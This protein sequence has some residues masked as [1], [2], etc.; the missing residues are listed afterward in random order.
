M[1]F[2]NFIQLI[3][4]ALLSFYYVIFFSK[5]GFFIKYLIND[6]VLYFFKS[7]KSIKIIII[8]I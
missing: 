2:G 1:I 8:S 6:N 7:F 5:N 4:F 3:D